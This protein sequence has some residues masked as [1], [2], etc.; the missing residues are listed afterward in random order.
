VPNL[1]LTAERQAVL[2]AMA[3]ADPTTEAGRYYTYIFSATPLNLGSQFYIANWNLL[4][5]MI[6]GDVS[7]ANACLTTYLAQCDFIASERA[8]LRKLQ[9]Y[10]GEEMETALV[11]DWLFSILTDAQKLRFHAAFDAHIDSILGHASW[12]L[13]YGTNLNDSDWTIFAYFGLA[14]MALAGDGAT[15]YPRAATL[16]DQNVIKPTAAPV[17]GMTATAADFTTV[18]NT[19]KKYVEMAEGGEWM[20]SP[21]YNLGTVPY[22]LMGAE[23]IYTKTGVEYFPEVREFQEA[24]ALHLAHVYTPGFGTRFEW[25]DVQASDIRSIAPY[26]STALMGMIAGLEQDDPTT[27]PFAKATL[28]AFKA[29]NATNTYINKPTPKFFYFYD[30]EAATGTW[31]PSSDHNINECP[32]QGQLYHRSGWSA[33]DSA[34]MAQAWNQ[35]YIQH[36]HF[37]ATNFQLWRKGQWAIDYPRF[38]GSTIPKW[39][40]YA[41]CA[42]GMLHSGVG[43][44]PEAYGLI[45]MEAD[46]DY[47]Y[48][49]GCTGGHFAASGG[50]NPKPYFL[51]E[52]TRSTLYLPSTDGSSD[53]IVIYDRSDCEDPRDLTNYS[54]YSTAEKALFD[55]SGVP[56][57][58]WVLHTPVSPTVGDTGFSWSLTDQSVEVST[59]LPVNQTVGIIN[60]TT[61]Y[62]ALITAGT[63]VSSQC[64]VASERKYFVWISP[65]VEAQYDTF[66]N[67]VA[68][69]NTGVSVTSALIASFDGA[70]VEGAL[71]KRTGQNNTLVLFSEA[72]GDPITGLPNVNNRAVY[73]PQMLLQ[74]SMR[75]T[76]YEQFSVH[77]TSDSPS[78][79]FYLA[80]LFTGDSWVYQLDGGGNVA[81][82]VSENGMGRATISGTGA[83]TLTVAPGVVVPPPPPPDPDPDPDPIPDPDPVIVVPP[84]GTLNIRFGPEAI[85][86]PSVSINITISVE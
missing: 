58:Q 76:I 11:Y 31:P 47:A 39:N 35:P 79:D 83:H 82:T 41:F 74:I 7:Y 49:A 1:L 19:I 3:T 20:E 29:A 46:D 25:N 70:S 30:P 73:D 4:R 42:N 21:P 16:L 48:L 34:F 12:P 28:A 40:T 69:K 8:A 23:G 54:T 24:L 26:Y 63:L 14:F 43:R 27:G 84:S 5:Y 55:T 52:W 71:I 10:H 81:L 53:V 13:S 80:D 62:P 32:G 78:T 33:S 44:V 86:E 59:L 37:V 56:L 68:A 61:K 57:K 60:E 18:R 50:Y 6:S 75:K 17:G 72:Q 22:L 36:Q 38:Y 85:T 77:F 65:T 67:V 9:P 51:H 64:P 15:S 2:D 66:L 45:G